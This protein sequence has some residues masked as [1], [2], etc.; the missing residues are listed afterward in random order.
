MLNPFRN[1]VVGDP[2][3]VPEADVGDIGWL[4]FEAC[5]KAIAT[6][7]AEHRTTGVL[8][9]GEPGSGKTH[10]IRR[11]RA[12]LA[13][14][15][16][17]RLR[18]TLFVYVRLMTTA[19][20]IWRHLRRRITDDFLRA[21]PDGTMQLEWM[22]YRRLAA[23][24]SHGDLLDR[25][26]RELKGDLPWDERAFTHALAATLRRLPESRLASLDLFHTLDGE[27]HLPPGLVQ[28]LR[29]LAGRRDL[30]LAHAWLRGDSLTASELERLGIAEDP[31]LDEDP[32]YAAREIIM[33]LARLSGEEMPMLFCFDQVEA[34]ETIPGDLSGFVAFGSVA[35][36]L[37]DEAKNLVLVSC[38]QSAVLGKFRRADYARL[39]EHPVHLPSLGRQDALRLIQARL[40]ASPGYAWIPREAELDPVFNEQ[41]KA[42]ARAI[43]N[44]AAELFDRTVSPDPPPVIPPGY[45]L[46]QEWDNRVERSAETIPQGNV[47]DVFG[48]GIPALAAASRG[49]WRARN[50]SGD[51]DI[52]LESQAGHI[53]ISLCNQKNM[54]SLAARLRRL[55]AFTA[56]GSGARLVLLRDP[57]LPIAKTARAT[58]RYL[59]DLTK[60]GARLV[61]PSLEALQA[62]EAL[63]TLL[64]D[65][66][67]GDLN[68]NGSQVSPQTVQEWVAQNVPPCLNRLMEEITGN[69]KVSDADAQLR[70]DLLELLEAR[71][72]LPLEE[73]ARELEQQPAIIRKLVEASPE[74]AGIL[75]G[76]PPV[77]YR[78]VPAALV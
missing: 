23:E 76:P 9:R 64:A 13:E 27:A 6:T 34:L 15:P 40:A 33:A 11:L 26:K 32:E 22:V 37:H 45:F 66:R 3:E 47:D 36:T 39:A 52:R 2:W 67:A 14:S 56:G 21:T 78:L 5:C 30:S 57:S 24:G 28:V 31:L 58:R 41:G 16:D 59:D 43:L 63:R 55:A 73:A 42:S 44:R 18:E 17:H 69:E 65:A 29:R 38:M 25:W 35:S 8:I 7:L 61:R 70:E 48:Q 20:M 60:A 54:R 1:A 51:I 19:A 10:V 62:L 4:A 77:L 74:L 46:Q 75:E 53:G 49:N 50:G 68:Q 12:H 71:C 72:L